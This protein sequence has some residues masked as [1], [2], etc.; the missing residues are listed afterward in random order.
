[1][2]D[3]KYDAVAFFLV[4]LAVGIW[5]FGYALPRQEALM[6]IAGCMEDNSRHA[7]DVCV[8]SLNAL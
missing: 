8:E 5:F 7:Y 3:N 4:I 1:M 6:S 2:N